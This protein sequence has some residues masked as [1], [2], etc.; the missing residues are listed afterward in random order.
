MCQIST[1]LFSTSL[2]SAV[3]AAV[4]I[5]AVVIFTMVMLMMVT[6]DIGI[7]IQLT[8]QE[9]GY[10]AIGTAGDT[11]VN[12]NAGLSQCHLSTAANAAAD[13]HIDAQIVKK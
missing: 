5:A 13:Q 9:C 10:S 11:A 6:P 7:V 2:M 4:L 1:H 8:G 3:T 12:R